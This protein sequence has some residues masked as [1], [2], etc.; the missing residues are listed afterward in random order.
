ME[1]FKA[2]SLSFLQALPILFAAFLTTGDESFNVSDDLDSI[3]AHTLLLPL[4]PDSYSFTAIVHPL[5]V[6]GK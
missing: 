5:Y 2:S 6:R 1:H 4:K 3:S